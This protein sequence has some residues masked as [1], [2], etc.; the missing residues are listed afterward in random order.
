MCECKESVSVHLCC[1]L[2]QCSGYKKPVYVN[3]QTQGIAL[4]W[5]LG[6]L[7]IQV[8]PDLS[9]SNFLISFQMHV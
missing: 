3:S 4:K 7:I 2:V 9:T 8:D 5:F 1:V 6:R